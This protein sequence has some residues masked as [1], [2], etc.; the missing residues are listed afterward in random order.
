MLARP[1]VLGKVPSAFLARDGGREVDDGAL[2]WTV[3]LSALA[4]SNAELA[5]P[6][7]YSELLPDKLKS[8]PRACTLICNPN[9]RLDHSNGRSFA[10][11]HF[12]SPRR[13][14]IDR[15]VYWKHISV[16]VQ[17]MISHSYRRGGHHAVFTECSCKV[18]REEA[19][20]TERNANANDTPRV[21]A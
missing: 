2:K 15:Y 4:S 3:E 17:Q 6:S 18:S 13:M 5:W 7:A 12:S 10:S 1:R 16:P 19:G 9:A 14:L 11:V 8:E 20:I 21:S